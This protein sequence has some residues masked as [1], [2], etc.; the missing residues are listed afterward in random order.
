MSFMSVRSRSRVRSASSAARP[1]SASSGAAEHAAS[2]S[3]TVRPAAA[4]SSGMA[5][6]PGSL[7]GIASPEHMH[8]GRDAGAVLESDVLG[9]D[10]VLPPFVLVGVLGL[11]W[12]DV[13]P[14]G[15]EFLHAP[16]EGTAVTGEL[17]GGRERREGRVPEMEP[18][19]PLGLEFLDGHLVDR[20][21][22]PWRGV[23]LAAAE[24]MHPPGPGAVDR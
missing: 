8:Q 22:D 7:D 19:H 16:V 12:V 1:T 18:G 15:P 13:P 10:D 11:R 9:Q 5:F 3:M 20:F 14:I 6:P 23:R 17:G 21:H 24:V 4:I 2:M